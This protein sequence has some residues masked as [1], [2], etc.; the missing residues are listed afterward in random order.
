MSFFGVQIQVALQRTDAIIYYSYQN[1]RCGKHGKYGNFIP[2]INSRR[3]S[4][5]VEKGKSQKIPDTS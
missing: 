3:V 4:Y 1:G 5:E 2:H